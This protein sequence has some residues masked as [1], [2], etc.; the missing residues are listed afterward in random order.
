MASKNVVEK[1]VERG[2]RFSDIEEDPRRLLTRISGYEK[3][4]I[5][6]LEKAVEPL[7][8]VVGNIMNNAERAKLKCN[9]PPADNLSVDQSAA[10]FLYTME[11]NKK[12]E[13]VYYVLNSTLREENREHL[14]LWFLYLRLLLSALAMLPSLPI[15]VYRGIRSNERNFYKRG[16]KDIYW[17]GFSS[18]TTD[19]HV[20][21]DS[22]FLGSRGARTLFSIHC[23]TGKDIKN[24]SAVPQEHEILLPPARRFEVV[25]VV[26]Q[27][28]EL[29]L[30]QLEEIES[31]VQL[32]DLGPQNIVSP[33]AT[34]KGSSTA[35]ASL[36]P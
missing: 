25:A 10:I 32:I 3:K 24:H 8:H 4:P 35:A 36:G 2:Q 23:K 31:P 30:I 14:K 22:P 11:M 5:V 15:H 29:T 17:W 16:D 26:P 7:G 6:A 34:G 9:K 20:F 13:C 27:G 18:C 19:M 28:P 21:N 1:E 33:T 12:Q